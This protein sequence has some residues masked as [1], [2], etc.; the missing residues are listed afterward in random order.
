MLPYA[1]EAN[2]IKIVNEKL[3]EGGVTPSKDAIISIVNEAIE[4][5][6]IDAVA[7]GEVITDEP[8]RL[9]EGRG[10]I[11]KSTSRFKFSIFMPLSIMETED[12][13]KVNSYLNGSK[14]C[15]WTDEETGDTYLTSFVFYS[16]DMII[17]FNSGDELD[18]GNIGMNQFEVY[19]DF[20]AD[21]REVF[22]QNSISLSGESSSGPNYQVV[23]NNPWHTGNLPGDINCT[24][25]EVDEN[26]MLLRLTYKVIAEE[27]T[28]VETRVFSI[29]N[30][31]AGTYFVVWNIERNHIIYETTEGDPQPTSSYLEYYPN[32]VGF[33]NGEE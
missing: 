6:E 4:S 13:D 9:I 7:S 10:M 5:G 28:P 3:K 23:S 20:D 18:I 2:V 8:I 12:E 19:F 1:T 29:I 26:Y 32:I 27:E 33:Y 22:I 24:K 14:L 21:V 16:D 17:E 11:R 30:I 15:V 31:D 25:I